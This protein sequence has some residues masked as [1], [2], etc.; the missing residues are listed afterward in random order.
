MN[1]N[2]IAIFLIIIGIAAGILKNFQSNT[3]IDNNDVA[4]LNIE[5]PSEEILT[6]VLP[7]SKLVTDPTDRA[8][9]AIFNQEF[10]T[11]I[12][13]YDTDNQKVN[14][15]YVLAA[16]KF[17]KGSL[18]DKY[19]GLDNG[20]ITLLKDVVTEENHILSQEEKNELGKVFSGL[21]WSLIQ[22]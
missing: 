7:V 17:F 6:M 5:K 1:K 9:L 14:D 13:Q 15:L 12:V 18:K 21:A 22:K 10:S 4:I 8:K 20:F 19:D 11:R 2:T 3:V 16:S